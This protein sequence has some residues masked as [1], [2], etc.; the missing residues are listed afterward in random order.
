MSC[1][2]P[3]SCSI[4]H[5]CK[6]SPISRYTIYSDCLNGLSIEYSLSWSKMASSS[7]AI[8]L[9]QLHL[10]SRARA[11]ALPRCCHRSSIP[12]Q[13]GVLR[14]RIGSRHASTESSATETTTTVAPKKEGNGLRRAAL[15]TSLAVTLFAGYIYLTDT[16]ASI[17]RY[18]V[19]PLIRLI[20][21]DAEDAHHAGV[22]ALRR[23]YD[24]GLHP[25]ERGNPDGDGSLET[26]VLFPSIWII[27]RIL[28]L[29]QLLL[30][31]WVQAL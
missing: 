31:F 23:L 21:P 8:T 6:R 30:G 14:L 9:K 3:R 29:S 28:V 13:R 11:A 2:F 20:Y 16:R 26:E 27:A 24:L 15:G 1:G 17:H 5:N 7:I 18:G 25:R 10:S 12:Q 4:S 22:K 19:V